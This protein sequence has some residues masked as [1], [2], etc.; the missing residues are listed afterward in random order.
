MT[1]SN[2]SI[3]AVASHGGPTKAAGES[4]QVRKRQ[5]GGTPRTFSESTNGLTNIVP[6][7]TQIPHGSCCSVVNAN[8]EIEAFFMV[9]VLS[10]FERQ[11][12]S[13]A[14]SVAQIHPVGNTFA[15]GTDTLDSFRT[16][17]ESRR[18]EFS[19]LPLHFILNQ[20]CG[21]YAG[22]VRHEAYSGGCV[23]WYYIDTLREQ[24]AERCAQIAA[25]LRICSLIRIDEN[26]TSV[27]IMDQQEKEC[28]ASTP[29]AVLY[30]VHCIQ[31]QLHG[32][33]VTEYNSGLV[34]LWLYTCYTKQVVIMPHSDMYNL[35]Q[36]SLS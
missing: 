25:Q 1:K 30:F 23:R 17:I 22:I 32:Q 3:K 8:H 18:R 24:K 4:R 16:C 12:F 14:L 13:G 31:E 9:E 21:H 33:V 36:H 34:R 10:L 11:A 20:R 7:S 5:R 29:Y 15:H 28:G 26:L 2:E 35:H 19:V 6:N 27:P